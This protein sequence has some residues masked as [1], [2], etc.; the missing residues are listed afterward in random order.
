MPSGGGDWWAAGPLPGF[1]RWPSDNLPAIRLS[2]LAA[3]QLLFYR[4]FALAL[5]SQAQSQLIDAPLDA[6]EYS[7]IRL[8]RAPVRI[9]H[10]PLLDFLPIP[11]NSPFPAPH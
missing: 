6:L 4:V 2:F 8:C 7:L 3:M 9:L 5:F 11:D 1:P 10:H